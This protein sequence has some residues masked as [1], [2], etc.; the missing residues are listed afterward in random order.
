MRANGAAV[1]WSMESLGLGGGG[2]A[3]MGLLCGW[4]IVGWV[5]FSVGMCGCPSVATYRALQAGQ[6]G[7][8]AV[9]WGERERARWGMG[10]EGVLS[11]GRVFY[12]FVAWL[13][14]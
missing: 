5:G 4:D 12:G 11:C 8:G 13:L 1:S 3:R 14:G 7:R 10:E 6:S 9:Q 2:V